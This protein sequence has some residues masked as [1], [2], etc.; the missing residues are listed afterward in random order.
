MGALAILLLLERE[1]P[2]LGYCV[3]G[4]LY[5]QDHVARRHVID[6]LPNLMVVIGSHG[7]KEV[8]CFHGLDGRY[9]LL[10]PITKARRVFKSRTCDTQGS[11]LGKS[12][13]KGR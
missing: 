9:D 1:E 11:D 4:E 3:S 7:L 13:F 8:T 2:E 6:I 5:V 10:T 12:G